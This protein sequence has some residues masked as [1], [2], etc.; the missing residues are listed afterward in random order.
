MLD[1][2]YIHK[3]KITTTTKTKQNT[4][5]KPPNPSSSGAYQ[6]KILLSFSGFEIYRDATAHA[7]TFSRAGVGYGRD[8]TWTEEHENIPPE[9]NLGDEVCL[10]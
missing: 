3:T 2:I 7:H 1:T 4:P 6:K 8:L 10:N 5:N 9:T